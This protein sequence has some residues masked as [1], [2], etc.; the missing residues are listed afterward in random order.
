M[1]CIQPI[2]HF[3]EKPRPPRLVARVTPGQEVDSSATVT[4]PGCSLCTVAFISCRNWTASRFSRPPWM[5]GVQ[6]PSG[7]E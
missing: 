7:R 4:I 6:P 5:F 2:F 3:M 1:S